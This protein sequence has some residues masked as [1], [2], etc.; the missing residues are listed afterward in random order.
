MRSENDVAKLYRSRYE[1][2][3]QVTTGSDPTTDSVINALMGRLDNEENLTD[4]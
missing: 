3:T 4:F 2:I 1:S